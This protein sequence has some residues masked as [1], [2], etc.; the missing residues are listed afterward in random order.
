LTASPMQLTG[1]TRTDHI[2]VFEGSERLIGQFV[3]VAIEG[4]T[5]FTLFGNV[6]TS[7][8]VGAENGRLQSIHLPARETAATRVSLPLI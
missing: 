5:A 7:E 2:V 8:Q 6:V 1:R 3:Q 4:A